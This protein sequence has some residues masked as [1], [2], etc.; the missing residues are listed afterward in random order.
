LTADGIVGRNTW[1]NLFTGGAASP[2]PPS[3][4]GSP[5]KSRLENLFKGIS[6]QYR[7]SLY[8]Y[9]KMLNFSISILICEPF[10]RLR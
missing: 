1:A 2:P 6:A 7:N 10:C 8:D 4:G 9:I 5:S 3:G